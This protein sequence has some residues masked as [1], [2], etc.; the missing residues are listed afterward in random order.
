MTIELI[1]RT[2]HMS[3]ATLRAH[4]RTIYGKWDVRNQAAFVATARRL[5]VI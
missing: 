3:P 4:L 1:A 5:G 2:Q